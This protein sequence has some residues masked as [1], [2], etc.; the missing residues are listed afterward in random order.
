MKYRDLYSVEEISEK[1]KE[2]KDE[3][4][5][6]DSSKP[7]KFSVLSVDEVQYKNKDD[8]DGLGFRFAL[9]DENKKVHKLFIPVIFYSKD[10][11]PFGS[12]D[13]KVVLNGFMQ[14][15]A[16]AA[17]KNGDDFVELFKSLIADKVLGY[18]IEIK[19]HKPENGFQNLNYINVLGLAEVSLYD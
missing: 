11:N 13:F 1:K 12:R 15:E 8:R 17:A 2:K 6:F 5:F 16:F 3:K 4:V 9:E 10:G 7:I 18:E 14:K 19:F